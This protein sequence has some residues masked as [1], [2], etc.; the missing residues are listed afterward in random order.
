MKQG[1]F[2]N[3]CKSKQIQQ[4]K[5]TINQI[6][7]YNRGIFATNTI[8]PDEVILKVP[9]RILLSTDKADQ[10]LNGIDCSQLNETQILGLCLLTEISKGAKSQWNEYFKTLPQKFFTFHCFRPFE[11][12]LL[13]IDYAVN[14]AQ[15]V[16]L[17]TI[18]NWSKIKKIMKELRISETLRTFGSWA[19]C[20]GC[21]SSRTMY[22]PWADVGTLT[23]FGD[24]FNHVQPPLQCTPQIGGN[25][26]LITTENIEYKQGGSG[27]FNSQNQCYEI[28][29]GDGYKKGEQVCLTYGVY[30]NLELLELYGFQIEQ[31]QQDIALLPISMFE[32]DGV[33]QE[34]CGLHFNGQ[35]TWK[36][37]T[38]LRLKYCKNPQQRL[39]V[40][41][42]EMLCEIDKEREVARVLSDVIL[43]VL[44][45]LQTSSIQDDLILIQNN[46]LLQEIGV[47]VVKWR[48]RYK[49]I[50]QQGYVNCFNFIN[51]KEC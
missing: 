16:R 36:L 46:D 43:S 45:L 32:I 28:F 34:E 31:N 27:S 44:K 25:Q 49:L 26:L 17:Q 35:P 38:N 10:I 5:I 15:Q 9:Q 23:P 12:E 33:Q 37:I 1:D 8:D 21:I 22:V 7:S 39:K 40:L 4:N 11:I 30:S 18:N 13:Q 47:L 51:R 14:R 20:E 29:A 24:M 42:G 2:L 6:D 41:E 3:W 50:L 48:L 19:W